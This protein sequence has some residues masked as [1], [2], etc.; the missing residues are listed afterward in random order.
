MDSV[1]QFLS[2]VAAGAKVSAVKSQLELARKLN[3]RSKLVQKRKLQRQRIKKL[4]KEL[5]TIEAQ[6]QIVNSDI[7]RIEECVNTG[8]DNEDD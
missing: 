4:A 1:T 5:T 2:N 8:S 6:I 3:E 7:Q